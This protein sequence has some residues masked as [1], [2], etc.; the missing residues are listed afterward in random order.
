MNHQPND[1]I[2]AYQ[3]GGMNWEYR[4]RGLSRGYWIS[5]EKFREPGYFG[6]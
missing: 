1:I 5:T 4:H 2:V 6:I 3:S